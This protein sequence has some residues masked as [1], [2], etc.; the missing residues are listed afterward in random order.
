MEGAPR[1]AGMTG[2]KLSLS[3]STVA[4]C[5]FLLFGYDQG[6]MSGIISAKPFND[7]FPATRDNATMQGFVTAIYEIGCLAGAMFIIWAGDVLGRR[8]SIMLGATIMILGV[9]IQVT[10]FPGHDP[11][12]QFIVGRVITGVGNGMNTSTIPTYQAECSRTS[13]RGLLICIEGGVIAFGTL[14]SY[15]IDFGASYGPED[16]TWRFPIAFQVVFGVFIVVGMW[17][18]PES[19]RWLCMHDKFEEGE[20]VIAALQGKPVSHNDVQLQKTIVLDSIRAS[21]EGGKAAPLSAVFSN[22]KTQHFRRMLLGVSSQI[23]QQI[24]GCNAVIYYFPI[25]FEKSIHQTHTMSML[26]GGVNMIVYS[27]FA[28]TSWFLIERVGRRKLFLYGT[29]G[30]CL[31]MVLTFSCLIPGTESAAKGAAVGLFTYIASFGATWLPLPWLYPAEISPI[32]TRAK[33]NALS[34]CSNWLFN[35]TIVMIT[36]VMLEGIGWGT[37]LFFAVVNACFLPIIYFFYPETARR[38]LEEIDLI[39]A[40]G[41]TENTSYVTAAKNLPYLSEQEIREMMI[42]YGLASNDG[43]LGAGSAFTPGSEIDG[44]KHGVEGLD[45]LDESSTGSPDR[46][47]GEGK[48]A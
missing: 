45:T 46:A 31:S 33:A 19:P 30:Q 48:M 43:S 35:F 16:L 12:A 23:M 27:I 36:P 3:I 39:F 2:Q 11:L 25:L 4:T 6:I 34:T 29:V 20:R 17:F 28:T 1:Y 44:E 26:L 10:S 18:M 42:Q 7:V 14:I 5:G 47:E 37:Y 15:W 13:N 40:K 22:G 38:S 32:K 21:G 24:G 8:K 41:F 9:I